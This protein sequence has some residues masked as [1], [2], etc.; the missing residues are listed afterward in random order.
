MMAAT[1]PFIHPALFY[2][3]D[4]EYLDNLVPFIRD[5]R[6]YGQP[7]AAAVPTKKLGL[8]ESALGH[9]AKHIT[10]IDMTEA[11][12]NPG[13]IIPGV[14]RAFADDHPS[15]HV[16]II[17]EPIWP[18]RSDEEYPACVQHEALINAAFRDR[19]VT[20]VCPYDVRRLESH[21]V[22]D[23][24]A[25]HPLV[26]EAGHEQV[27][28]GY[29]PDAAIAR[30]NLPLNGTREAASCTVRTAADLSAAR[31]FAATEAERAGL[32]R[33]RISDLELIASEL[34]TNSLQHTPGACQLSVWADAEHL[35]CEARDIGQIT[36]PLAG[37]R[38]PV[39]GQPDGRGL[40]IV[41]HLAD[42]VR[43]HTAPGGTTIRA[44]LRLDAKLR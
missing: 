6:R 4:Q 2:R 37:R 12:R 39:D 15:T 18:G 3:S 19:R 33:R 24:M 29:A 42:L 5:G 11:G 43:V 7:V 30:Y 16:R 28:T 44:Y 31:H 36:D 27:S 14:L 20:I 17:G 22:A 41:N 26:W 13:R 1:E 8:L 10:L 25:T 32:D 9:D 21:V 38:P 34:A 35:V 40:L 23:A